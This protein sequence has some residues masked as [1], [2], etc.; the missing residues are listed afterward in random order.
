MDHPAAGVD[1]DPV[2]LIRLREEHAW[3]RWQLATKA[4]VTRDS[5]AKYE[6]GHRRPKPGTLQALCEVLDCEPMD[7]LR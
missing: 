4:G 5:I 1:L 6:N 7:L 2:K 3:S